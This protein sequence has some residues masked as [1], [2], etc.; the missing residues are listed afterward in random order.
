MDQLRQRLPSSWDLHVDEEA[1]GTRPL[2]ALLQLTAPDGQQLALAVDAKRLVNTRDVPFLLE[3]MLSAAFDGPAVDS[4]TPVLVARYLSPAT[5]ERIADAGAAYVDATGNLLVQADRPALYLSDRGADRDPWRGPGRPRG[6]LKGE[7]AARVVRALIDVAPPYTVADLAKRAGTST[8][9][10]Y[11]AVEFLEQEDLLSRQPHG[12]IN[13]VR[14]R[15]LLMRWSEDYGL[16]LSDAVQTYLEPRGLD[17]LLARL[18]E[19]TDL[20]Y[21]LT[22]SLAAARFEAYAPSRLAMLYVE[23][24]TVMAAGLGLRATRS[25]ANVAL[26]AAKYRMAFERSQVVDG[27][28]MAAPSQVVV[29]LLSGPGRSPNEAAALLEWMEANEPRWR[30]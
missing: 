16:W 15:A 17:A 7:P 14:W 8:G 19:F 25:G 20:D 18:R 29:D 21:V 11:R 6:S 26:A 9:A 12:S 4:P 13:A 24:P 3:Q 28:R 23:D 22:G 30:R 5:R 27:V 1:R 10:T 2:D